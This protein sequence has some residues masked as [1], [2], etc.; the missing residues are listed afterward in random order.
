MFLG[1]IATIA[2]L[3]LAGA[4]AAWGWPGS[5]ALVALVPG[6]LLGGTYGHVR[7]ARQGAHPIRPGVIALGLVLGGV[8]LVAS[9]AVFRAVNEPAAQE[10]A[11]ERVIEVPR[12]DLWRVV[13]DLE[14]RP[15]WSPL[16]ADIEAIGEPGPVAVGQRFRVSMRFEGQPLAA[17]NTLTVVEAPRHL[18]WAITL[19]G[20]ARLEDLTE[21]ITLEPQG[22]NTRATVVVRYR[23]PSVLGRVVNR[24]G[25]RQHFDDAVQRAVNGLAAYAL[26]H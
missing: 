17:E 2:A 12:E 8:T 1:P 10:L 13:A 6:V 20:G 22:L 26:E 5:Y 23:V 25:V 19:V 24:L 15:R 14:T 16:V 3:L 9:L 4:T 21:S 7:R 18:A 11:A